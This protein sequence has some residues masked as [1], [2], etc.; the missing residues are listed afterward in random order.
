MVQ[1]KQNRAE[2]DLTAIT[3]LP[4]LPFH[5]YKHI[6]IKNVVIYEACCHI[7]WRALTNVIIPYEKPNT[8]IPTNGSLVGWCTLLSFGCVHTLQRNIT[9]FIVQQPRRPSS[10][11][12]SP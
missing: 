7:S 10:V 12:T 8:N 1:K 4:E 3:K 9:A 2:Q 6:K 5:I 11:L